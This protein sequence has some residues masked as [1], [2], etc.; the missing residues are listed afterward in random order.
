MIELKLQPY[1]QY[2]CM[3][4]DA[5]VEKAKYHSYADID[6][7]EISCVNAKRCEYMKRYLAKYASK[8][9]EDDKD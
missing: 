3:D 4:F 8:E 6:K 9:N 7:I 2:G 5:K 1:C